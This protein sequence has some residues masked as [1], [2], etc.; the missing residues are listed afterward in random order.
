M[1]FSSHVNMIS[2]RHLGKLISFIILL[3]G[4]N[5]AVFAQSSNSSSPVLTGDS[6]TPCVY[7]LN[8]HLMYG[9]NFCSTEGV[10]TILSQVK[11]IKYD[12][13][14]Y[15]ANTDKLLYLL[16]LNHY[17]CTD[18]NLN[19]LKLC[20]YDDNGNQMPSFSSEQKNVLLDL[21]T[22]FSFN[23]CPFTNHSTSI[24]SSSSSIHTISNPLKQFKSGVP[25]KNVK[26][27]NGLEL[28]I[29]AEDGTPACVT[30]NGSIKL[31]QRGW[32][33]IP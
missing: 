32:Y 33:K 8:G 21:Q 16:V 6:D 26:C 5:S 27:Q 12:I 14:S 29:K 13:I 23:I 31:A 10:P 15:L 24:N 4:Y 18:C 22:N 3:M 25:A 30:H 17:Q 9:S 11:T 2:M 19:S 7:L 28:I 20:V 1:L